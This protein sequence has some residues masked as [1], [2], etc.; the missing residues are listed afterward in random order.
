MFYRFE[1][2][3]ELS[4]EVPKLKSSEL[5]M[6]ACIFKVVRNTYQGDM[7][8]IFIQ[9]PGAV[10][11]LAT[12]TSSK[13]LLVKQFRAP[14]GEWLWEIPAGTLEKNEL[15]LSC[16]Q[17]ELEEETGYVSQD[18]KYLFQVVLAPGYSSE[19]IHFFRAQNAK[20]V[21]KPRQGDADEVIYC[22]E[23]D[24]EQA[25]RMLRDGEIKDAKTMIAIWQWLGENK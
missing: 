4:L 18:W 3:E 21:A 15:P 16:A 9:H 7:R 25:Y 10:S 12:T 1:E 2:N 6:D 8:R 20:P 24:A 23:V 14:V 13:L 5:I 22:W 17:R 11:I 19:V